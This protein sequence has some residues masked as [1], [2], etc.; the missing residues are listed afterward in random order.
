MLYRTPDGKLVQIN[1]L[2]FVNDS[3]YYKKIKSIYSP[4]K[5]EKNQ[6]YEENKCLIK[7]LVCCN[8]F[9]LNIL[10]MAKTLKRK[11]SIKTKKN[12]KPKPFVFSV[13][14]YKSGDGMLTVYGV[15]VYGIIYI[16]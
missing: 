5:Y 4:Q 14:N 3:I 16:Q 11:K 6:Y 2:D 9:S 10:S 13:E 12:K 1:K 7:S 8:L 15:L